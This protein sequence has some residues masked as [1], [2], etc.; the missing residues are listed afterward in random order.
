[1]HIVVDETLHSGETQ[2]GTVVATCRMPHRHHTDPITIFAHNFPILKAA[3]G[4]T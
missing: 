2:Q 1:M 3:R 4:G